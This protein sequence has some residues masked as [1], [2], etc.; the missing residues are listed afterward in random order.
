M[1]HI[2]IT[3]E[4]QPLA[5]DGIVTTAVTKGTEKKA[6]GGKMSKDLSAFAG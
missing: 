3:S 5:F 6:I 1:N 4:V 2:K